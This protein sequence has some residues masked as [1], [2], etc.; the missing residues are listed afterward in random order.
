LQ[1]TLIASALQNLGYRVTFLVPDFGQPNKVVTGQGIALIKT[2]PEMA[3]RKPHRFLSDILCLFR[4]MNRAGADIYYQRTSAAVTGVTALFCKLKKKP[5]V[6]SVASNM[7]LDG[8]TRLYLKRYSYA[9]YRYGLKHATAVVVQTE[10]QLRLLKETMGRSGVLIRST[11][12]HP[13]E[14]GQQGVRQHVLWVGSFRRLRRPEM[15]VELARSLPQHKFVMV[16][17]RAAGEE[18]L[19]DKIGANAGNI[20]NLH[21]T[22]AVPYKEVGRYFSEA[23]VFVNTSSA[24]GFPNT[25]LETWCRGVP[26]VGTFDADGLIAK[27]GLGRYCSTV[28]EL[29][30]A[31]EELMRDDV[32]RASIGERAIRYV[33][34]HHSPEGV[35]ARYDEL[36]MHLYSEKHSKD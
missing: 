29:K 9:L 13:E 26:V 17:G 14:A 4:A 10:D 15:F 31:V 18:R 22:G 8:S 35:G 25:Y 1:Q 12:A 23:K 36:F 27:Y 7:D 20:P 21:L 3:V 32:L 16:G 34:E 5:F 24:E 33:A 19:F 28:D 30:D 2:R 11:F 6:F